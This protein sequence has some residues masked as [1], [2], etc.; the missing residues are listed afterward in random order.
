MI[1]MVLYRTSTLGRP[2]ELSARV[3][4]VTER[5]W[6]VARFRR[7]GHRGAGPITRHRTLCLAQAAARIW[8]EQEKVVGER[9]RGG[10]ES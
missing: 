8:I 1:V 5:L 9:A 4:R 7:G 10:Y 2:A 3:E 6:R